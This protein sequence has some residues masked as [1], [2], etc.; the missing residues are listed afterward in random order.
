MAL[1]SAGGKQ[2]TWFWWLLLGLGVSHDPDFGRW[3]TKD[4]ILVAFDG[5]GCFP[6]LQFG[7]V[8]NTDVP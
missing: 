5:G 1:F 6:W 8:G 4:V 3:E 7:V 2:G